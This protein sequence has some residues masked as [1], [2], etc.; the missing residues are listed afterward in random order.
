MDYGVIAFIQMLMY[1][2]SLGHRKAKV[3]FKS[4]FSSSMLLSFSK[5]FAISAAM[6]M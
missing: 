3:T 2:S 5:N 4:E 1:I 6:L